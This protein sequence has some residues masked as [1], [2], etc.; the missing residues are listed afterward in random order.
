MKKRGFWFCLIGVLIGSFVLSGNLLFAQ[1]KGPSS[2]VIRGIYQDILASTD[3][4]GDGK[5]SMTECMAI[6]TDKSKIEK[7]CKYWDANGDG[8]ITED[9]YVKQARNIM[10]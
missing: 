2:A 4:N 8:V 6:S 1:G 10:R 7:D 3:K 5:L 9:E